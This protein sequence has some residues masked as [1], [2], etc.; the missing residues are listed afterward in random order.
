MLKDKTMN[1]QLHVT[2]YKYSFSPDTHL[3]IHNILFNRYNR[4]HAVD[5]SYN[6][7]TELI[8]SKGEWLIQ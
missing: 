3:I 6:A 8:K 7:N 4:T 2:N 1:H 5:K